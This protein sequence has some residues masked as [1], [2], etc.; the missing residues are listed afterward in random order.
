MT[1]ERL[2][3]RRNAET[4]AFE[5]GG[6]RWS[7]SFARFSDGLSKPFVTRSTGR[8]IG[9]LAAALA[10]SVLNIGV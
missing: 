1:R 10:A 5:Q 9:P 8:D 4:I 2:P 3:D 6:R 7:A